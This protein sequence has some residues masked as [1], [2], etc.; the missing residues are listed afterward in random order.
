M[1]GENSRAKW[2]L[3]L[4]YF[5]EH[6]EH[7]N[8]ISLGGNNGCLPF[9]AVTGGFP[10]PVCDFAGG[11]SY[12]TPG[13][14]RAL[15]NNQFFSLDVKT[16]ALFGETTIKLAERW[17]TTI[18]LRWTK[19]TKDQDYNFWIVNGIASLGPAGGVANLAGLP[20]AGILVSPGNPEG[21]LYTLS[22]LAQGGPVPQT[23]YSDDWSQVTPKVGVEFKPAEN[24]LYYLSYSKG[25]KSGGFNGRPSPNAQGQFG[26]SAYQPEKIDSYEVGAKTQFAD[27]RVRLNVAVFQSN[28][29]GIQL[30]AVDSASGFFNTLN[31]AES[32]IRGVEVE[33]QARPVAAFQVQAGLG[34]LK[35]EYRTLD[36]SVLSAGI[37]FGMHL[38][39]TPKFNGSLGAQ[40]T[41]GLAGG[42]FTLRGDYTYRSEFWF[43][44]ANT[45][46][47]RQGGD[48]LANA[49][50]TYEFG[51]GR[52]T[53]AA[54]G[55]NLADKFYRTNVQDVI[56]AG[57]CIAFAAVSPPREW[58]AEL[59][60]RFGR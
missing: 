48:G 55:L 23:A 35:D 33:V 52:W 60:Y 46:L 12:A 59:R 47:N 19:E 38:P 22:P 49:R 50:A 40:Y 39:L 14:D 2:L 24:L 1:S 20:P 42:N 54:Y 5:D 34:Y 11:Q 6:N 53:V 10:Y 29:K 58:G 27:N 57:L 43:E 4:F 31:A 37:N 36:P 8:K 45:A 30:L 21:R 44:A 32:R 9:P 13:V 51:D 26:I 16:E 7:L 3:G 18:G 25:F 41:W 28:Y 56:G 15:F 17:S